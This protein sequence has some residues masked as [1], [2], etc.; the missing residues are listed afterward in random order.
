VASRPH[1]ARDSFS[2]VF[3][4]RPPHRR[5]KSALSLTMFKQSPEPARR[6]EGEGERAQRRRSEAGLSVCGKV[7]LVQFFVPEA[8]TYIA[9]TAQ[10]NGRNKGWIFVETMK[11]SRDTVNFTPTF[12][13][14]TVANHRRVFFAC[15]ALPCASSRWA[16][17]VANI[18]CSGALLVRR[19]QSHGH[20][21]RGGL[22]TARTSQR[23]R[24]WP[25]Y[26]AVPSITRGSHGVERLCWQPPKC[27][28]PPKCTQLCLGSGFRLVTFSHRGGTSEP[29][30]PSV[31]DLSREPNA[32]FSPS[33]RLLLL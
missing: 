23:W 29:T 15:L 13:Q 27:T 7:E 24:S 21:R 28:L 17:K 2:R 4:R 20:A 26:C 25:A 16:R 18:V 11:W 31:V 12:R 3:Q 5:G 22:G 9:Q 10:A 33:L 30:A 19:S 6:G 1:R 14:I 8:V 32:R